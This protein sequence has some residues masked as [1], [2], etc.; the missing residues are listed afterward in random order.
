MLIS[1]SALFNL[2]IALQKTY[3]PIAQIS[4]ILQPADMRVIQP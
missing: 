4:T 1:E 3:A 2:R